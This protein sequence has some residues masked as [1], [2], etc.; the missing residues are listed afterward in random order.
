MQ[1]RSSTTSQIAA[2]SAPAAARLRS[3]STRLPTSSTTALSLGSTRSLGSFGS[4]QSHESTDSGVS[5]LQAELNALKSRNL[6]LGQELAT[7]VSR[8]PMAPTSVSDATPQPPPSTPAAGE[9]V[10]VMLRRRLTEVLHSPVREG[11]PPVVEQIEVR[12]CVESFGLPFAETQGDPWPSIF[13]T[14]ST[15]VSLAR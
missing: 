14:V 5:A 9:A 4:A 8:I 12:F 10:N 7:V 2:E 1:P 13:H 6:R 15:F 11:L 3:L